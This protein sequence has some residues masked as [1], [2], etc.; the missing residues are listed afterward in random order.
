[1]DKFLTKTKEELKHYVYVLIDPRDNKIFYVGKGQDDRVFEHAKNAL[2]IQDKSDKLDTIRDIIKNGQKV[3]HY[4]IRHGLKDSETAFIVESVLIDFL[5]FKDFS[6]VAKI[7]NI[8]AGHYSFDR[9]IKTVEEIGLLYDCKPIEKFEHNVLAINING[10]YEKKKNEEDG[11]YQATRASWVL[12]PNKANNVD[13]IF[14]EYHNIVR[15]IFVP[16]P[17]NNG[18]WNWIQENPLE[19]NRRKFRYAF[20]GEICINEKI[21]ELYLNKM[22][23]NKAPGTSNPIRYFYKTSNNITC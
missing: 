6:E 9:G 19:N 1:M 20:E 18:D 4:I 22:L 7:A 13:Y 21:R 5:T 16:I 17:K 23:P 15:E 12:E 3:K 10:Q 2:V 11:I 8:V 14:S